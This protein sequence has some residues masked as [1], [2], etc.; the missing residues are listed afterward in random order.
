[1]STLLW[2]KGFKGYQ[3]YW[4]NVVLPY[5]YTTEDSEHLAFNNKFKSIR[6]II[7]NVFCSAK[8]FRICSD[9]LRVKTT[10]LHHAKEVDDMIWR[11]CL[12]IVNL[13]RCLLKAFPVIIQNQLNDN[14]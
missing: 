8:K 5:M 2:D 6:T 3:N 11:L 7:E 1:M 9:K 13:L 14:E 10:Q 12:G 4:K